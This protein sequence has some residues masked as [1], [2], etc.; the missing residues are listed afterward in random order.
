MLRLCCRF[1]QVNVVQWPNDQLELR[2]VE[3]G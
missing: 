3:I 1:G 2:F